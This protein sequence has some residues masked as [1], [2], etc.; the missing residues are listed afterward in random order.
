M[1]RQPDPSAWLW[2][3]SKRETEEEVGLVGLV[4]REGLPEI[5]SIIV[6]SQQGLGYAFEALACVRD[7]G[8]GYFGLPAQYGYQLTSNQR[9]IGLMLKLGF[10]R[11]PIGTDRI[12]WRLDR[13]VWAAFRG[14]RNDPCSSEIE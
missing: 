10:E 9:S 11:V 8:F 7:E 5:G 3:A 4:V 13:E 14:Q 12:Q 1:T 6:S 2:M